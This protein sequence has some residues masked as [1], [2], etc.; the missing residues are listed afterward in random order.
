V[1]HLLCSHG[2]LLQCT[3][4]AMCRLGGDEVGEEEEVVE[5]SLS[6]ED[7]RTGQ[8]GRLSDGEERTGFDQI[9]HCADMARI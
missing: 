2:F 9:R 8:D 3:D 5:Q 1:N 7:Q 4:E 6:G